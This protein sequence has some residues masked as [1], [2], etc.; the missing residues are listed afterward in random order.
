[1]Y[2]IVD[3]CDFIFL[4]DFLIYFQYGHPLDKGIVVLLTDFSILHSYEF[5][6]YNNNKLLFP[7]HEYNF[8]EFIVTNKFEYIIYNTFSGE[9]ISTVP[10]NYFNM[11]IGIDTIYQ[12]TIFSIK[13]G[14]ILIP[15]SI[16]NSEECRDFI[17]HDLDSDETYTVK[18][19]DCDSLYIL[20]D[21]IIKSYDTT[22]HEKYILIDYISNLKNNRTES[23][24]IY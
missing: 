2:E 6:I 18:I 12:K 7:F 21:L 14:F 1:V 3:V 13:Y 17:F 5:D 9:K 22:I 20:N 23:E 24:S 15:T 16:I 19:R 10:I 11:T 8:C 4:N